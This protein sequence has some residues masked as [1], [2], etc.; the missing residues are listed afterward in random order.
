MADNI[1]V[2]LRPDGAFDVEVRQAGRT[3]RHVVTVPETLAAD[4]G[5][6][7]TDGSRVVEVSFVFLLER[8]PASSILRRFDL[9]VIGDYFPEY[10]TELSDRLR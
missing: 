9:D 5:S 7:G 1:T 2:S 10:R 8:E 6:A 3:T 4:V